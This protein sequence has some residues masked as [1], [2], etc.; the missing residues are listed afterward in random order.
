MKALRGLIVALVTAI[1][2]YGV[3]WLAS[4]NSV[5][6]Q[7]PLYTGS[8]FFLC[9]LLSFGINWLVFLPSAAA[10]TEKFYDLTGSVTYLSMVGVGVALAPSLDLRS[11]L[12]AGAV[13]IWALRLGLFLFGRISKDG[14][15]RRFAKIKTNPFRFLA[16]WSIQALWCLLTAAAALAILCSPVKKGPDLFLYLG[17]AMWVLGFAIE[18]IADGQKSAFRKDPTNKEAFITSGLWAWSRHPNY[19]GEI[20]L[21]TGMAVVAIP[22]LTG[23]LWIAIVSPLFVTFLLTKVSGIPLLDA[24]ALQR[25]GEDPAYQDYRRRTPV[26]FPKPPSR[27]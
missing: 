3:A 11:M 5:E 2:G 17:A 18:V 12:A 27:G 21:W 25:W 16:A 1:V 22:V 19:F 6:V 20:L 24:A 23:G 14:E 15:D 13:A 9:A 26:L 8:L 4:L 10:R 7:T